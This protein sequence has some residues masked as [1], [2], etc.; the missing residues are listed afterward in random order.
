MPATTLL[1]AIAV[2]SGRWLSPLATVKDADGERGRA[3]L[4]RL[5]MIDEHLLRDI[6][7]REDVY[8]FHRDR[9]SGV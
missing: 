7:F 9:F 6:G 4:K 1:G 3:R 8:R 2:I 5:P